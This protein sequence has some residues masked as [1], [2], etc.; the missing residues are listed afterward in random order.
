[1][2]TAVDQVLLALRAA[3]LCGAATIWAER[4]AE[5]RDWV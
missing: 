4:A 1:M 3:W 2:V 5:A